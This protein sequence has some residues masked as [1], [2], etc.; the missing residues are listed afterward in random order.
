MKIRF[1]HNKFMDQY[2]GPVSFTRIGE[3]QDVTDAI[4]DYLLSTHNDKFV[5]IEDTPQSSGDENTPIDTPN[6]VIIEDTTAQVIGFIKNNEPVGIMDIVKSLDSTYTKA[7]TVVDR[8]MKEQVLSRD[9]EKK[10][11]I[12]RR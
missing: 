2:H 12:K 3:I 7:R 5:K 9:P 11:S 10:Y 8:L 6:I 4:G 1:V